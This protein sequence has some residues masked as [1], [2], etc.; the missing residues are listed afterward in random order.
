MVNKNTSI[1]LTETVPKQFG[2]LDGEDACDEFSLATRRSPGRAYGLLER[3]VRNAGYNDVQSIN[4]Y[5][6]G[7]DGNYTGENYRRIFGSD[8]VGIGAITRT[9]K[10]A[11]QL[12]A[13]I[14][15]VSPKT[16]VILGGPHFIFNPEIGF[17]YGADVV[18]LGEGEGALP[19]IL[20]TGFDLESLS[21]VKGIAYKKGDD[22]IRTLQRELLTPDKFIH[23]YYDEVTR[24]KT[25]FGS[26][27]GSRGCVNNCDFCQDPL[28]NRGKYRN[29]PLEFVVEERRVAGNMAPTVFYVDNNIAGNKTKLIELSYAIEANG[30]NR[31]FNICQI[32]SKSLRDPEI[33]D[34]L[35]RMGISMAC[36]GYEHVTNS[37]LQ[38]I[39]KPCTQEDNDEAC[40]VLKGLGILNHAMLM[41]GGNDTRE[42]LEYTLQWAIK[43]VDTAQFFPVGN[44]AG[45]P[46]DLRMRREGRVLI[47]GIESYPLTD[48]HHVAV[49]ADNLSPYEQQVITDNMYY[50]FYSPKN[51]ALRLAKAL[52]SFRFS[53]VPLKFGVLM[54][55]NIQH[56]VDKVAKSKQ[57]LAHLEYLKS[58]S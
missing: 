15:Y 54:Y 16:K 28:I 7:D 12:T 40:K 57:H 19:E 48:G 58:L 38:L 13:R 33:Q 49:R 26:V 44:L 35:K 22:V 8:V 20:D 50:E 21:H 9:A 55:T 53:Q 56:G 31:G 32:T 1:T 47:D 37:N 10:Q 45:T 30:L 11:L 36:I 18:C 42:S 3:A 43:N 5:H 25:S 23:P 2:I 27:E 39:G 4:P 46:F 51:N 14:K 34:A 41:T 17:E 29:K 24:E 6:H 52:T